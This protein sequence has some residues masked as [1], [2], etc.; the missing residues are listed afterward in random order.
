MT[1]E[2]AEGQE[3]SAEGL[4]EEIAPEDLVGDETAELEAVSEPEEAESSTAE[5]AEEPAPSEGKE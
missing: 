3:T 5:P 4:V 1:A 2:S